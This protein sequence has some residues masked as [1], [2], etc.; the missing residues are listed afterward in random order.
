[1]DGFINILSS[2]SD[3]ESVGNLT[4]TRMTAGN[5]INGELSKVVANQKLSKGTRPAVDNRV[6]ISK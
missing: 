1:M 2:F 5:S 4:N 3:S 6:L